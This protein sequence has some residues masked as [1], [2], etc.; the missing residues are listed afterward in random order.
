MIPLDAMIAEDLSCPICHDTFTDPVIL[1]CS[2]SFCSACLQRWWTEK[3]TLDDPPRNLALKNLCE[4]KEQTQRL[5]SLHSEKLKIFCLDHQEPVCIVCRDSKT[6]KNHQ[7]R[8]VDEVAQDQREELQKSLKLLREKLT[9]LQEF[10]GD[11]DQ[12]VKFIKVQSQ[13][14]EQ[15]IREQFQKLRLFLQQEEKVRVAALTTDITDLSVA[16]RAFLVTQTTPGVLCQHKSFNSQVK[17]GV[18]RGP[19]SC[20]F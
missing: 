11:C 17:K 20:R 16:I 3:K 4:G 13:K 5:C 1:S 8:P 7:F 2:H 15:Q 9:L 10:R 14:T 12:T 18:S 6:H 19:L